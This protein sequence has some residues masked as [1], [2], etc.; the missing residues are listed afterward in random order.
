MHPNPYQQQ[1]KVDIFPFT[2]VFDH[3]HLPDGTPIVF[4]T[5][6]DPNHVSRYITTAPQ[7]RLWLQRAYQ[8][9]RAAETNLS[10]PNGST[11]HVDIDKALSQTDE[12]NPPPDP[13]ASGEQPPTSPP[14]S[15]PPGT[16][17]GPSEPIRRPAPTTDSPPPDLS[18]S[19]E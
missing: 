14:W 8:E 11:A 5:V 17:Q 2:T 18:D 16:P 13:S 12:N 9:L 3:G 1:Q 10:L 4:F 6:Q 7:F 15:F 19:L